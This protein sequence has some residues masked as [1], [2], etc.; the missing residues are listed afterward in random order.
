MQSEECVRFMQV[1]LE[2]RQRQIAAGMDPDA[3]WARGGA[4]KL[5]QALEGFADDDIIGNISGGGSE[6]RGTANM[7][8]TADDRGDADEDLSLDEQYLGL[9]IN[10]EVS[11]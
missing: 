3:E 1:A 7:T 5:D 11:P 9:Q 8:P 6:V 4:W 10:D 2:R